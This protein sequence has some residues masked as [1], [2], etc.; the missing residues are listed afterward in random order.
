MSIR[1][2][3][4]AAVTLLWALDAHAQQTDASTATYETPEGQLTVHSAQPGPRTYA[5][6]PPQYEPV[7]VLQPGYV[8]VPGY[9]Q[10]RDGRYVWR[11][12]YRE[13]GR[14]GYHWREPRWEQG[15]HGWQMRDGGWDRGDDG[16]WRGRD[17]D[18]D[19]GRRDRDDRY[20]CPPGH[21]RKGEC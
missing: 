12:G 13:H 4:I 10:W 15:P 5:P 21:A 7:P 3:A 19:H 16:R 14:P 2:L 17:R 9:W 18:W 11:R 6:P 20:H 8:W 1:M